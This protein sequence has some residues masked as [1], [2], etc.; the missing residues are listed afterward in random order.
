MS[1]LSCL[2]L[3]VMMNSLRRRRDDSAVKIPG[4]AFLAEVEIQK[5]SFIPVAA[6]EEA[7]PAVSPRQKAAKSTTLTRQKSWKKSEV[8]TP[9]L[10]DCSKSNCFSKSKPQ[11]A[12]TCYWGSIACALNSS[13]VQMCQ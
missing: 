12:G 1:C 5:E 2:A 6:P 7:T 4:K 11:P 3:F 9:M 13:D 8:C 10:D